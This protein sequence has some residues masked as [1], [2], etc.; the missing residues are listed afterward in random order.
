MT[1]SKEHVLFGVIFL[2]LLYLLFKVNSISNELNDI[3]KESNK[4]STLLNDI[5][6]NIENKFEK[7]FGDVNELIGPN[8][9]GQKI[10]GPNGIGQKIL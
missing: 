2:T 5:K 6:Q 7:Q 9:I 10:L 1:I 8:G 4:Y 3:K